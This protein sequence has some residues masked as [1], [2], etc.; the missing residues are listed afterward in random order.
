MLPYK[1]LTYN[2]IIHKKSF[3]FNRPQNFFSQF[4]YMDFMSP[5]SSLSFE[6]WVP[7]GDFY[8][9]SNTECM[10]T[11]VPVNVQKNSEQKKMGSFNSPV[12][13]GTQKLSASIST[14][15]YHLSF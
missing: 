9:V 6:K 14:M 5:H 4:V 11:Q 3:N 2:N 1:F 12:I 7:L 10:V 13:A 8:I 15:L